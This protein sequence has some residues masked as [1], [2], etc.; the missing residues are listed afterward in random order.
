MEMYVNAKL[1][2]FPIISIYISTLYCLLVS[3]LYS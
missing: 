2:P 1:S 3:L